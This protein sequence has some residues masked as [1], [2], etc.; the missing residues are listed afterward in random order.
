MNINTKKLHERGVS[1]WLDNITRKMLNNGTL[2]RYINELSIKGLT[3]NPTIFDN[4]IAKS[5][6]YDTAIREAPAHLDSEQLFFNLAIED[7]QR[8]A[9]L[10]RPI[11]NHTNKVD[12]FVSLE[13]SPLLAYD[14]EKTIE[15]AQTI[16]KKVNRE[17]VFIKI[18]GTTEGLAA[19]EQVTAAGIPVNVT[20]LFSDEQYKA[21]AEAWLRGIEM[22]IAR[23]LYSDIRSVASVFV[24]RWDKAVAGKVSSSLQ[25]KLGI[26]VSQKTY[27]AY[28]DFLK[29][30]RV[31]KIMNAGVSPQRLLWASTGAKDPSVSDV[32][33]IESLISPFTVNT[34]PENTLHAFADHGQAEGG[35]T[36]WSA[37][38]DEI[39]HDFRKEGVDITVLAAELQADG[40]ESFI[41]SWTHLLQSVKQKRQKET[42]V[43]S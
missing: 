32:I 21:A 22:R 39:L 15:A 17:N 13:V 42:E 4:A 27:E 2:E 8:A 35:L 37:D 14:T 1:L 33:Y 43:K 9:D 25:N 3:S 23:G 36:S 40:A 10:F 29:S 11:Y 5:G 30:E 18:P 38:N 24:S 41:Q 31:Q 12:G 7:I 26:A 6:D 19:I 34:T 28:R 16:F 20:L